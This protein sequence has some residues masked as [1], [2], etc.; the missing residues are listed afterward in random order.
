M[1][2]MHGGQFVRAQSLTGPVVGYV[3]RT[4]DGQRIRIH[5]A[6]GAK[7]PES[8]RLM[9]HDLPL[10]A[11]L[12]HH[13]WPIPGSESKYCPITGARKASVPA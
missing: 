4:T 13:T 2:A 9:G 1:D 11:F 7:D 8:E 12:A 5:C 6:V 3:V 10:S